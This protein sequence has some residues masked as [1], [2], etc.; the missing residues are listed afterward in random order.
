MLIRDGHDCIHYLKTLDS[1]AGNPNQLVH[2]GESKDDHV[3]PGY[4][5]GAC[6]GS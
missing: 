6:S 1:F 3:K 4:D 5:A 2:Y